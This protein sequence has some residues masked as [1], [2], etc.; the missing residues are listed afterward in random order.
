MQFRLLPT[1]E[2][3]DRMQSNVNQ[4][5]LIAPSTLDAV[6]DILEDSADQYTPIAGGTELMVALGAGRLQ[7]RKFVSLWNLPELRFIETS[8]N[9]LT[10]G[11]GSTFTDIRRHP[12]IAAEFPILA[13]AASWTGSIANQNRATIGGNIVNASPAADSPPALLVYDAELAIV[14][15][16]HQRTIPYCGFHLSY[17]KIALAPQELVHSIKLVR[18]THGY[19][20]Y[21]RKVGPRNAQAISKVALAGLAR[22]EKNLI[23]EIRLGAASLCEIPTRLSVTE[24]SLTGKQINSE[25]MAAAGTA[26][27]SEVKPIDDIRSTAKYR[28]S[29]AANLLGEFLRSL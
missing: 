1:P 28:V 21:I 24:Q 3:R 12:I 23:A 13:K 26:L 22:M 5:E 17:K 2:P 27:V 15:A 10:I 14:S 8:T 6:L 11:A 4:Y 7:P 20:Q 25:T 9:A 29:V 16:K 19:R 18:N